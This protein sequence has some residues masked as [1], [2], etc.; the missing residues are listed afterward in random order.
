MNVTQM[1][2]MSC[3]NWKMPKFARICQIEFDSSGY[4]AIPKDDIQVVTK[5]GAMK[6]LKRLTRVCCSSIMSVYLWTI[7]VVRV[8]RILMLLHWRART[9][10]ML[11]ISVA[12]KSSTSIAYQALNNW[13]SNSLPPFVS[14]SSAVSLSCISWIS[15]SSAPSAFASAIF[16][17]YDLKEA[18]SSVSVTKNSMQMKI[19]TVTLKSTTTVFSVFFQMPSAPGA[20]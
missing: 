11:E 8:P 16:I 4:A 7:A 1:T 17:N 15:E 3:I 2:T 18:T 5:Y 12:K 14:P 9:K 20:C 6:Q 13:G 19:N 10:I